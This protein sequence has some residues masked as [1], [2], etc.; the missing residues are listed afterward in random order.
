MSDLMQERLDRAER[1]LT[2][3]G[4]TYTEGA[5]EWKPPIGPSASPLLDKIDLQRE[6]ILEMSTTFSTRLA[7]ATSQHLVMAGLLRESRRSVNYQMGMQRSDTGHRETFADL[8]QRIDALLAAQVPEPAVP[9]ALVALSDIASLQRYTLGGHCDSFG[10]DCGA[11]MEP[12][13]EGEY[14]LLAD[15]LPLASRTQEGL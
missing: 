3:S 5:Q 10:Q 14:I 15:A 4:F 6:Q 1:A 8:L 12:D 7:D 2:R 9:D 13:D 11:E